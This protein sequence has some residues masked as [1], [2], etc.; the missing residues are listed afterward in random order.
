[1]KA[2]AEGESGWLMTMG[3]V[4]VGF[5]DF[6]SWCLF[7]VVHQWDAGDVVCVGFWWVVVYWVVWCVYR[8]GELCG[9]DER[10]NGRDG[11]VRSDLDVE[12]RRE[13]RQRGRR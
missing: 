5:G 6:V 12:R 8:D 9:D 2:I 10:A 13:Q 3:W 11:H 1:M 4:G 7:A